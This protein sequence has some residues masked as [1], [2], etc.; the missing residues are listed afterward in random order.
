QQPEI[1][2][3]I[4]DIQLDEERFSFHAQVDVNSIDSDEITSFW[5]LRNRQTGATLVSEK[6]GDGTI[7]FHVKNMAEGNYYLS[8][9]FSHMCIVQ[10]VIV[11][12]SESADKTDIE[13]TEGYMS[14]SIYNNQKNSFKIRVQQVKRVDQIKWKLK[15]RRT[16]QSAKKSGNAESAFQ[17]WAK[18]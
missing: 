16:A 17:K 4:S 1:A 5:V 3:R 8:L 2:Y 13:I 7:T 11:K 15:Q 14:K 10:G 6:S 12:R 9:F 18:R